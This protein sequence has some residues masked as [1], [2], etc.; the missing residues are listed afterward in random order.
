MRQGSYFINAQVYTNSS[1]EL[2]VGAFI[3]IENLSNKSD[4]K[5]KTTKKHNFKVYF[6][7]Y[8]R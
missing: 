3:L 7:E 5:K 2:I 1:L 4:K 6:C 8:F